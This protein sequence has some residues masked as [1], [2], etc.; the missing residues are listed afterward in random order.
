MYEVSLCNRSTHTGHSL[1]Q[2]DFYHRACSF[3]Q[4]RSLQFLLSNL[5]SVPL[6]KEPKLARSHP[7]TVRQLSGG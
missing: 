5:D 7:P 3:N 2:E 4:E 6:E 1:A